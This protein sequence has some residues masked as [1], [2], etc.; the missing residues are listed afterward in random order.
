[1]YAPP[2]RWS[3]G[4]QSRQTVNYGRESRGSRNQESLCWRGPA[5]IYWTGT[6]YVSPY[7]CYAVAQ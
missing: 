4:F 5:T 2:K 6:D 7:S 3:E 1:M